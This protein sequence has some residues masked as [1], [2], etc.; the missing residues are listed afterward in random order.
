MSGRSLVIGTRGSALA[1]AQ[2]GLVA[3][4]LARHHPG[5]EIRTVRIVTR[6][7]HV[8][9]QPLADIGGKGLFVAEIEE[10]LREGR[11]DLAVHSAKDL[12]TELPSDL[13]LAAFP[14][15]ADSRDVLVSRSG[16]RL[17]ALP[18]GA[19]IGT[20]SPRRAC[21]VAA[22]RPDLR[23]VPIRGNVDTRLRK[24]ERGEYD[25]LVLAAAGLLRLGREDAVSEWLS[26]EVMLPAAGQGALALQVR[27]E[28]A[29][30]Y[31]LLAPL[32]DPATAVAVTAER[33]FLNTLGAGC[34]AAAGASAR[35]EGGEL[36]IH[37]LIGTVD[38]RN[39]RGHARC[40]LEHAAGIGSALAVA[41]LDRGG[42]SFLAEGALAGPGKG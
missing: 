32:D 29:T 34:S 3:A 16:E 23:P 21:Q 30:T 18:P 26:P 35:I 17:G 24:L 20:S 8:L 37:G 7:D 4:A 39:V 10:A 6:G 12:P 14:P 42:R 19:R 2:T 33:A 40:P 1:E 25:A 15:R 41:L 38:G 11:I 27:A 28:D 13:S 31:A 9:D 36:E 22:L 5:L